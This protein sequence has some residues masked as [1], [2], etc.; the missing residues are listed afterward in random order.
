MAMAAGATIAAHDPSSATRPR[1]PVLG[2]PSSDDPHRVEETFGIPMSIVH[3]P[4][5]ASPGS[6]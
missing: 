3:A 5:E 1:L 4:T 2:R 6:R